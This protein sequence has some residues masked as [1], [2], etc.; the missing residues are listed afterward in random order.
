VVS[1]VTD[2]TINATWNFT[3][4]IATA[5][6]AQLDDLD[7]GGQSANAIVSVTGKALRVQ[8]DD[9]RTAGPPWTFTAITPGLTFVGGGQIFD[10][11]GTTT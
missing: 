4:V 5:D 2:G 8:Y 11:T 10:Q 3:D 9:P 7:I 1:V 6:P